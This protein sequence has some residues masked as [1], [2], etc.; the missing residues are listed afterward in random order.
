MANSDVSVVIRSCGRAALLRRAFACVEAQTVPPKEVILVGIGAGGIEA[1]ATAPA[2]WLMRLVPVPEG[3]IRGGALNDGVRASLAPWVAFLDDDDTWAPTFL[4]EMTAAA[5]VQG[6]HPDFGAIICRTEA[7]YE[8]V[9]GDVVTP[10][11]REPFNPGLEQVRPEALFQKNRFTINAA[12]WKRTVF[13]AV[14]GFSEVLPVLEDWDFNLRAAV[15]FQLAVLPCMLARY[16]LR[17]RT[18]PLPNTRMR[19]HGR[20]AAQLQRE[21]FKSGLL[22]PRSSAGHWRQMIWLASA[23]LSRGRARFGDWRRWR[24]R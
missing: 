8:R 9:E 7:V 1:A 12:L 14:G 23:S 3:R 13:D 2:P 22:G 10:C 20:I 24:A 15:R 6:S 18:D 16:H 17:P 19:E 11:G 21:W 4:E 5:E